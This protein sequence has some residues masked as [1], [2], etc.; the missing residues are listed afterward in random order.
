MNNNEYIARIVSEKLNSGKPLILAMIISVNGSSPR[1]TGTKMVITNDGKYFGT[2]GGSL[3]EAITIKESK[4]VLIQKQSKYMVFELTDKDATSLG[5]ICGGKVIV[6]LDYIDVNDDN[7]EFFTKWRKTILSGQDFYIVTQLKEAASS[8]NITGRALMLINNTMFGQIT[9]S[10]D[11]LNQLI[12]QLT[13]IKTMSILTIGDHKLILDPIRKMK[14]VYFFGAGHVALPTSHIA[15]LTGFRV[16]I[17][18]DRPEYANIERFPEASEIHV[19]ESF[20]MAYNSLDIDSDSF[21][22]ILTRSHQYDREVLEQALKTKAG[23]IGMISSQRKR[24]IIYQAL[25]DKGIKREELERVHS[26][27]GLYIGGETP[28]EIAVSI[29]AE[30]ISERYKQKK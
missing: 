26:P 1:H 27:I 20:D 16:V 10:D 14:T 19:I 12:Q 7:K 15:A 5:M 11:D 23:Y 2:I 18:D 25:M 13:N 4:N 24:A 22:V 6:L 28:E 29:V 3:L 17:L 30:L 9:L 8:V 21:I